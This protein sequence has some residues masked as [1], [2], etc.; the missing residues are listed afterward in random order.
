[1][2]VLIILFKLKLKFTDDLY[3]SCVLISNNNGANKRLPLRVINNKPFSIC[4]AVG[5]RH[6]L[7]AL[8]QLLE[9]YELSKQCYY[10]FLNK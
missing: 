5:A 10:H 8:I 7:C 9:Q 2:K 4:S 1:M 3:S 6:A